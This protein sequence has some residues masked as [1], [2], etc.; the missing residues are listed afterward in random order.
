MSAEPRVCRVT[1]E[2]VPLPAMTYSATFYWDGMAHVSRSIRKTGAEFDPYDL[3]AA[4][5]LTQAPCQAQHHIPTGRHTRPSLTT[6]DLYLVPSSPPQAIDWEREAQSLTVSL[7]PGLLLT[8]A[9][10]VILRATGEL[11]WTRR[12]GHDQSITLYVHPLLIVDVASEPLRTDRV[13]IVPHFHPCDPLLHHI[14]L[15]LK[16]AIEAEGVANRLYAESLTNALAVHLLRRYATCRPPAAAC[17]GGLSKPKLRRTTEYIDAHLE[18]DLPL[19]EL[20]AV[21]QTSLAHF[22]RRFRQATGQTPHHYVI[23][24]RIERAKRLLTDTEWPLIE[25]GRRVGFTDQSY[26][27]AVFRKHVGTTPKGYRGGTQR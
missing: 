17:T 19:T 11:V 9:P 18:N 24:R 8:V 20:A 22:V 6:G 13:Q 4:L 26:F 3:L 15:V 16:T 5:P 12:E 27:T 14:T 23:M 25:I 10:D 21:A 2:R 7:D 1:A